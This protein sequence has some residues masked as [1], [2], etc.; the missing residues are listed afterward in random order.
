MLLATRAA[1]VPADA[2]ASTD[3]QPSSEFEVNLLSARSG[4]GGAA[5]SRGRRSSV[6]KSG[7]EYKFSR[8]PIA[9]GLGYGSVRTR[10]AGGAGKRRSGVGAGG[11]HGMASA[12]VKGLG[13]KVKP[14]RLQNGDSV[15]VD[16][17][18]NSCGYEQP[19][20]H[21]RLRCNSCGS[22][23]PLLDA[24]DAY[25]GKHTMQNYTNQ[26]AFTPESLANQS[27]RMSKVLTN[28]AHQTNEREG[29][30]G[31][32]LLADASAPASG[33]T[34]T[35]LTQVVKE[36][37]SNKLVMMARSMD[38]GSS[39]RA[40]G[41]GGLQNKRV[42]LGPGARHGMSAGAVRHLPASTR[43]V[44]LQ[45]GELIAL[46]QICRSCG[47]E[48]LPDWS[49]LRCQNCRLPLRQ[50]GD[51]VTEHQFRSIG[52]KQA[53]EFKKK[54]LRRERNATQQ[55]YSPW[56]T[57]ATHF[58]NNAAMQVY[59]MSGPT[60]RSIVD[61]SQI[62]KIGLEERRR[63]EEDRRRRKKANT[64]SVANLRSETNCISGDW[65]CAIEAKTGRE[66]YYN[67]RSRKATYRKPPE[68]AELV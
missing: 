56:D 4:Q 21:R 8:V 24:A 64:P 58:D 25:A 27:R 16:I 10:Q 63:A 47:F 55:K 22:P 19:P 54:M 59:G 36:Q 18:C 20:A 13:R 65:V 6:T 38:V 1:N 14:L 7:K 37:Q 67:T 68:I 57:S 32:L 50:L 35:Q 48:Q 43:N 52:L 3:S 28:Y 40:K 26:D 2:R 51:L 23:L 31:K 46:D 29:D 42:G 60:I 17:L 44:R 11:R 15:F 34:S 66:Y 9:R 12:A 49:G 39:A 45:N 62:D 30:E 5:R 53:N 33:S 61:S 41:Q